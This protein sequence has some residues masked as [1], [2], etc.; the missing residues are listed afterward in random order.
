MALKRKPRGGRKVGAK[1][2]WPT[3]LFSG[4]IW[5]I[6]WFSNDRKYAMLYKHIGTTK[7][8]ISAP[9]KELRIVG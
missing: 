8:M 5:S 3:P 9:V 1:V 2:L 7:G 6:A 4:H